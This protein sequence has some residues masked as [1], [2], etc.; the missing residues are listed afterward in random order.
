MLPNQLCVLVFWL[1]TMDR[2]WLLQ[3][4]QGMT[5]SPLWGPLQPSLGEVY[6][7]F[8]LVISRGFFKWIGL[9]IMMVFWQ[10]DT[11]SSR[12]WFA[13]WLCAE[14]GLSQ[15]LALPLTKWALTSEFLF[16]KYKCTHLKQGWCRELMLFLKT[17]WSRTVEIEKMIQLL[18]PVVVAP[19]DRKRMLIWG[20][21][22]FKFLLRPLPSKSLKLGSFKEKLSEDVGFD[23][24]QMKLKRNFPQ[25]WQRTSRNWFSKKALKL[26]VSYL[27]LE[28]TKSAA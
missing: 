6:T 26:W 4:F 16:R 22:T 11:T 19:S 25:D 24:F 8:S 1:G 21:N 17:F 28:V 3:V 18:H 13:S 23:F 7:R 2:H 20:H 15:L 27:N 12:L 10:V 5:W 9:I 14:Y